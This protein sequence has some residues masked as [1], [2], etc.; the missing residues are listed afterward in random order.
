MNKDVKTVGGLLLAARLG[1]G[2]SIESIAK[3]ICVR[4]C[5]LSAI[6]ANNFKELPEKTFA[7]GFVRAYAAALGLNEA[8]I[9][10]QFKEEF[11]DGEDASVLSPEIAMAPARRRMPAWLSPISG[12]AGV[13]LCWALFGG[14]VVPFNL[15]A[16]SQ[17][18][19][20]Q[21]DVAQLQAVQASLHSARDA[22]SKAAADVAATATAYLDP[23]PFID[24]GAFFS[25]AAN[26]GEKVSEAVSDTSVT[27]RAREDAW[28]RL[29][30][31]DGTEIWSGVL[32]EGQSYRPQLE[33]VAL[34]STS[35]AGGVSVSFD[36]EQLA[37]LGARGEVVTDMRLGSSHRMTAADTVGQSGTG[38]R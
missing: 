25:T 23:A 36:G 18:V 30:N 34:L 26:A 7:V 10:E 28:V 20:P 22:A 17:S 16:S 9:V 38:S 27:L 33:G 11:G 14:S 2:L 24:A 31:L 15:T 8:R 35:N 13:A 21:T 4:S 3:D 5:Y 29:S 32:R 37:S 12:V 19:D 6:E 1:R